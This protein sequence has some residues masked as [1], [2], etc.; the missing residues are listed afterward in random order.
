MKTSLEPLVVLPQFQDMQVALLDVLKSLSPE[1]WNRPTACEGWSVKDVAQHLWGDTVGIL[2]GVRDGMSVFSGGTW[3]EL[4]AFINQHNDLWVKATRRISTPMLCTLL[5]FTSTELLNYFQTLDPFAPGVPISW[6]GDGPAPNWMEI[7]REYTEFWMHQQ[8]IRDA[9][10]RPGLKERRFF[11]PVLQAFIRALPV[12]FRST[13]APL[14]TLVK[15]VI[16]GEAGDEWHL[17]REANGWM[18]YKHTDL[19]PS[20]T[21]TMDAETAWRLFTKGISREAAQ[22]H[23]SIEGDRLLGMRVLETVSII[24]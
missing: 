19:Q 21:V 20:S 17:V 16:S 9:I 5:E 13:S 22:A 11:N 4:V 1:D 8:H 14:D 10:N 6:A 15:L 18:I 7:A 2:S 3:S 12:T 23:T 24:A